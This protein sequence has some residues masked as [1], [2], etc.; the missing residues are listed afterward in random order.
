MTGAELIEAG[1]RKVTADLDRVR[2]ARYLVADFSAVNSFEVDSEAARASAAI[3]VGHLDA[4]EHLAIAIVAPSDLAF[5]TARLW[6]AY[7]DITAQQTQVFRSRAEAEAWIHAQ[8]E[9]S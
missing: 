2:A 9:R 7:A 3:V 5:G 1:K 8:L 4:L 6:Q